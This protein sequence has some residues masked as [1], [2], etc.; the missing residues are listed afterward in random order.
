MFE[1][2][3]RSTLTRIEKYKDLRESTYESLKTGH[4]NMLKMPSS[5]SIRQAI[6]SR[7]KKSTTS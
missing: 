5:P 3:N 4:R 1:P 2:Y 7:L 6:F